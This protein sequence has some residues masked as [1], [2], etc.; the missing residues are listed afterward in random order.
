MDRIYDRVVLVAAATALLL[1]LLWVASGM[2]TV[3]IVI[4]CSKRKG[5]A[6]ASKGGD[7]VDLEMS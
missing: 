4:W 1:F 7:A 5:K 2:L 3:Y 6:R